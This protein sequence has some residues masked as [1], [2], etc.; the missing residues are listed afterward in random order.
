[1]ILNRDLYFERLQQAQQPFQRHYL[2]MY[3]S[4]A[5]GIVTDPLLMSIPLDDHLVHRGDGVFEMF[6]CLDGGIYNLKAH[7]ER[8]QASSGTIGLALPQSPAQ[9]QQT[10]IET[11]RAACVRDCAVRVFVS[12]GPGSFGVNPYDCP[13]SQL[14]VIVSVLPPAFMTAHPQGATVITSAIP[15]KHPFFATMKN[16]NYL[17]NVLMKKE[18]I[19]AG[20]DFSVAFDASGHLAE[21]ATENVGIVSE[22]G[23]LVCPRLGNVLCGTTMSRALELAKTLVAEGVLQKAGY[24]DITRDEIR[25]AREMLIFGTTTDVTFVRRFDARDMPGHRPV[26]E[27]LSRL[28]LDDI[29]NST[30]HRTPIDP[31]A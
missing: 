4:L 8:L 14:Y 23:A 12:R 25:L 5:G 29:H 30:A 27:A 9:M 26:F 6:K 19:D 1:M 24:D 11:I 10:V 7:L 2:A 3:S 17:P 18:A 28:L 20:A 16:C 31:A 21:G 22:A 15:I 13:A